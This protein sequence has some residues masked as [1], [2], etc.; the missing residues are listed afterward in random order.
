MKTLALH[1]IVRNNEKELASTLECVVGL[2][3][4]III[5][6]TGSTD[7][8][9]EVA[10]FYGAEVYEFPWV[11]DFAAARNVGLS[12]V[13][14]DWAMWLDTGDI[15]KPES[16]V[17]FIG[18]KQSD[19]F[20]TDDYDLIWVPLNRQIDEQGNPLLTL[21]V[22]RVARMASN[23]QWERPV[24]ETLVVKDSRNTVFD[25]ASIDDPFTDVHGGSERN[26]RILDKMIKNGDNSPR[27][28][29]YRGQELFMLKRYKEAAEQWTEYLV[30][31]NNTWEDYQAYMGIGF[32]YHESGDKL[33]AVG[34]WLKAIGCDP[35]Q[36]DAWLYIAN[37]YKEIGQ[38]GKASIFMQACVGMKQ[39]QDG[40]PRN[41]TMYIGL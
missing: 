5:V 33:T 36:P 11:D 31:K 28:K 19:A 35:T 17:K 41:Q 2:F 3:D 16:L 8:T 21:L 9:I 1:M 13:I 7:K 38:D 40:R 18:M 23:P 25:L 20:Q 26:L 10:K 30:T 14:C 12:K 34:A 29:F 4:Q 32:C 6:D 24:H 27:T 39:T 22:P 37:V 15:I